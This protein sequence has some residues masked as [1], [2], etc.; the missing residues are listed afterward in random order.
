MRAKLFP[1]SGD[2]DRQQILADIVV[3]YSVHPEVRKL[4]SKLIRGCKD[5]DTRCELEAIY[6]FVKNNIRYTE[7]VSYVDSY[8]SPL[9]ILELGIAD[10][11][12]FT[13]LI[14]SLLASIGWTVGS[15]IISVKPD[16]P[17]HHIYSIVVFP[18]NCPIKFTKG[19]AIIPKKCMLIPLDA[20]VKHLKCCQE[21]PH[22]KEKNF[23]FV[24]EFIA[25]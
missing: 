25:L 23:L 18:K 9:R 6:S 3:K 24:P 19:K 2:L 22:A 5:Y 14:D 21:V 15:R 4:A 8:H 11:D 1:Y 7:D 10:C 17:F 20:S 13:I 12:D 16:K